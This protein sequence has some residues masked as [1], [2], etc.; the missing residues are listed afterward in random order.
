[1]LAAH[2]KTHIFKELLASDPADLP[3][4]DDKVLSY[5]PAEIRKKFGDYIPNHMLH[6]SI[7]MTVL[8]TEVV[9]DAGVLFYP[10]LKSG[11]ARARAPSH[12]PG[13]WPWR[14]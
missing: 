13:S 8:I 14:W 12:A 5:F 1:M 4:F 10:M 11:R 9:G 2:V 3:N 6:Q 7:G